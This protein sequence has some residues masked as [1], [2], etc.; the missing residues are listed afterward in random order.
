MWLIK[1]ACSLGCR[2]ISEQRLPNQE[3]QPG[4]SPPEHGGT[5]ESGSV[6][7][8]RSVHPLSSLDFLHPASMQ[9][10]T[11]RVAP[12]LV[13]RMLRYEHAGTIFFLHK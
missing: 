3:Q 1:P 2:L 11:W 6:T 8:G 10:Q 7:A 12:G 9:D 5:A 4:L 13:G